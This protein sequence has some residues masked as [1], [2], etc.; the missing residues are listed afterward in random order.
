MPHK[1]KALGKLAVVLCGCSGSSIL[2]RKCCVSIGLLAPAPMDMRWSGVAWFGASVG[3]CTS[4]SF[5]KGLEIVVVLY[6]TGGSELMSLCHLFEEE[7]LFPKPDRRQKSAY[8]LKR[9]ST[10][11]CF[12]PTN[13]HHQLKLIKVLLRDNTTINQSPLQNFTMTMSSLR[14]LILAA[15]LVATTTAF[16]PAPI[17]QQQL[18]AR[19]IFS[20]IPGHENDVEIEDMA[21]LALKMAG[22][23]AIKT[24]KDIVN[25]PPQLFDSMMRQASGVDQTNPAVLV[26]K[27]M[28]VLMFKMA[29]DVVYFP[30]IWTQRMVE[31]Q[32]LEEC[33]VEYDE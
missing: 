24:A 23:L 25:Y 5:L 3:L 13:T 27:L 29:H 30:M 2:L 8:L 1:H 26:A 20:S 7:N 12:P 32:S 6:T 15:V 17:R 14:F 21:P 31:C 28:G 10:L 33:E 11:T 22:V 19:A 4:I 16:A 18:P 9:M